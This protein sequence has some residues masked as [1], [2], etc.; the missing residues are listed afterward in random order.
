MKNFKVENWNQKQWKGTKREQTIKV[1][2][3]VQRDEK[4]HF[5]KVYTDVREHKDSYGIYQVAYV[6]GNITQKVMIERNVSWL[7]NR[8]AIE[9][10]TL[11][12]YRTS[13]VLNNVPI[14]KN[15]YFGFRIVAFSTDKSYLSS[16]KDDLKE[17]LK[18][19]IE[20][21]LDYDREEFWFD[22]YFG[23]EAP[24]IQNALNTENGKYY[25]TKENKFGNIVKEDY[26]ELSR[27]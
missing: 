4:G 12:I 19:W 23:Y 3:I 24:N 11:E 18:R 27:L 22:M 15:G 25:L 26:G 6:D 2:R 8:I 21:C 13:Y 20:E 1:K 10:K 5:V 9:N 17:R 14:S 16:I 7:D